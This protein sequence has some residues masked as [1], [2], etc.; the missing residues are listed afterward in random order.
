MA[1]RWW[2]ADPH[3]NNPNIS[4]Y[5]HRAWVKPCHLTPQGQWVSQE[6]ALE[7]A[8]ANNRTILNNHNNRVK[9]EDTTI[10]VGDVACKGNEK[11]VAGLKCKPVDIVAMHNGNYIV[12][13]GNHDCLSK[14]TRILTRDYGYLHYNEIKV[15]MIIPTL[16]LDT[17]IVEYFPINDL[18]I[19][20][21]TELCA[22]KTKSSEGQF[23]PRHEM[24][25][26]SYTKTR[27][28]NFGY[29]KVLAKELWNRKSHFVLPSSSPSGNEDYPISDDLL[30]LLGWIFTDGS[31]RNR[32]ISIY[33]SKSIYVQEITKLLSSLK[34]SFRETVR[35]RDI[36]SVCGKPLKKEPLDSHEFHMDRE[37]SQKILSILGIQSRTE[38]PKWLH[39][40]SD[41]Q[42]SILIHTMNCGNG[43]HN[44]SGTLTIWGNPDFL[45]KIMG[46]CVTHGLDSNV[47]IANGRGHYLSVH[48]KCSSRVILP[49]NR[50]IVPIKKD[51]VWCVN[52]KNHTIFTELNGKTIITGNCN[53][54]V[55][56][57]AEYMTIS[58]GHYHAGVQHVPLLDEKVYND[59]MALSPEQKEKSGF[60]N[61]MSSAMRDFCFRHAKYCREN[62]DFIICGHVHNKWKVKKIAGIW[63]INVGVD[64]CRYMPIDDQEVLTI[65]DKT[66]REQ[67]NGHA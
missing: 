26:R 12:I 30:K 57:V 14:E 32:R 47:I 31:I 5:C 25:V 50:S 61:N 16:N 6:A 2:T 1:K 35:K 59:Y 49:Q 46:I 9:P 15:G 58:I 28:G 62:L 38:I 27:N 33:Q 29:K 20:Q 37:C 3:Y 40:C 17:K 45:Y 11:G 66:I 10:C 55:K 42:I 56:T 8:E 64:V 43:T 21:A 63:H 53:N 67:G 52:V 19:N 18:V 4:L 22:F 7:V 36:V 23:T 44:K 39:S 54:G 34:L 51:V 13:E 65:Y 24:V 60:K 41:R 48:K